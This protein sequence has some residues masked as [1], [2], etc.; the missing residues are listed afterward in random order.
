LRHSSAGRGKSQA[1]HCHCAQSKGGTML[2]CALLRLSAEQVALKEL[3]TTTS[4][5]VLMRL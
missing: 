1:Q 4:E 3:R 2:H 5:L